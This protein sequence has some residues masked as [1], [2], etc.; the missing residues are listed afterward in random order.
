MSELVESVAKVIHDEIR[1]VLDGRPAVV[2]FL[3]HFGIIRIGHFY[4]EP[5]MIRTLFPPD[6]Y[7]LFA[8][9]ERVDG[10]SAM[11]GYQLTMQGI[12]TIKLPQ[13]FMPAMHCIYAPTSEPEEYQLDNVRY[14]FISFYELFNRFNL[15]MSRGCVP[16]CIGIPPALAR[17]YEATVESLG[18]G[19]DQPVVTLHVRE[20]G[21]AADSEGQGYR[22]ARIE[23]YLGAISAL[24]AEGFRVIRIGDESMTRLPDLGPNV[25]DAASAP[26]QAHG[27]LTGAFVEACAIMRSDFFIGMASG[28]YSISIATRI[29]T[30]VLNAPVTWN[31]CSPNPE[32]LVA[33]RKYRHAGSAEPL[34]FAEIG[35][36]L[37]FDRIDDIGPS[38][39]N[40]EITENSPELISAA[41]AEMRLR[42]GQDRGGAPVEMATDTLFRQRV[43]ELQAARN[44]LARSGELAGRKGPQM[45]ERVMV[46][47]GAPWVR[48][49]AMSLVDNPRFLE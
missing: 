27:V 13:V 2:F 48:L 31:A 32:D 21:F 23:N 1:P 45:R 42:F 26:V 43:A 9:H 29:P 17:Q 7:Q 30:L 28:P 39:L 4:I 14:M 15:A 47:F 8:V 40:V 46:S 12:S 22:N 41:V 37:A 35:R 18:I 44:E 33:F 3:F 10:I 25:W 6:E 5:M 49:S 24:A 36:H 16:H 19:P 38:E 11:P 20:A 34:S